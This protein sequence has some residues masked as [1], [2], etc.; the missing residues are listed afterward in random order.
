MSK[1]ANNK[2]SSPS[3]SD[4]GPPSPSKGAKGSPSKKVKRDKLNG[5]GKRTSRSDQVMSFMLKGDTAALVF[6]KAGSQMTSQPYVHPASRAIRTGD[7]R[8][9]A[10]SINNTI[11]VRSISCSSKRYIHT[12][13]P[14]SGRDIA[15]TIR[16][17]GNRV[18]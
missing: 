11:G 7:A 6:F 9:S 2:R 13:Y 12:R 16:C 8:T 10:W 4:Q 5:L 18:C 14:T 1:T 17:Y 3:K 15:S